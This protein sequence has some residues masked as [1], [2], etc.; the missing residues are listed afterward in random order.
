[1]FEAFLSG[2][3]LGAFIVFIVYEKWLK[4]KKA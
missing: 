4:K 3:I 1:V 2:L